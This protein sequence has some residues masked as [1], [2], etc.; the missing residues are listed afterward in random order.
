MTMR[1]IALRIAPFLLLGVLPVSA[2]A[3]VGDG[4]VRSSNSNAARTA[5]YLESV[6][7]NPSELM[8]FLRDMPKGADLHYHLSG[9]IY[10]ETYVKWAAQDGLCVDMQSHAL[11]RPPCDPSNNRVSAASALQN[12]T[13]YGQ[14][15]DAWSM[16]NWNDARVNGHDQFFGTFG[17]FGAASGS[18]HTADMLAEVASRA[19]ANHVS[20]MEIMWTPDGSRAS[21]LGRSVGWGDGDFAGLRDRLLAAGLRDTLTNTSR[22]I[23]TVFAKQKSVM[24]CGAGARVSGCDVE[25]R[26]IYQVLR[27]IPREQVFA[28]ILAG[29]EL[30]STDKRVVGL[31]LVQPEDDYVAMRDFSLHMRMIQFL[32]ALYPDVPVTLHAGELAVGLV[33]PEGLRF[34]INESVRVAGASRIGHGVAVAHEDSAVALLR[35]MAKRRVMVEVNL[36]S[37]AVILGVKG[38]EHPLR[39]YMKYGVPYAFSTDDEGVSRSDLTLEYRRAVEEQGLGYVAL[40]NSARNSID[41]SFA[42]AATK[43]RLRRE[44]DRAF[45]AFEVKYGAYR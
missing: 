45:A 29:F 36:T 23:D 2:G 42:D 32:R 20:Y 24:G 34:H 10:A 33:P 7:D 31:N 17:K 9:G 44:L 41:Y 6:R 30:A 39:L 12:A 13:L 21:G 40:K 27:A 43:S 35:E 25:V 11:Q 1:M 19:A 15:I 18:A 26:I 22:R 38:R 16:R 37:N 5:R 4:N 8:L 28:Q 14:L 3:Q